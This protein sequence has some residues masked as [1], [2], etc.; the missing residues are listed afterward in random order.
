MPKN[1]GHRYIGQGRK[2]R[3]I[4]FVAHSRFKF[5]LNNIDLRRSFFI[6]TLAQQ[7]ANQNQHHS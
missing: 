2:Q 6:G 5:L 3:S 1:S 7:L 4:P